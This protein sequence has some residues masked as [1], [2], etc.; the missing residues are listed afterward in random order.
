MISTKQ[1]SKNIETINSISVH[2]LSL[3]LVMGNEAIKCGDLNESLKWYSK[4]L[5]KAKEMKN[6]VKANEFYHLIITLL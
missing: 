4:G 3:Y 5:S 6:D 1:N 2:D